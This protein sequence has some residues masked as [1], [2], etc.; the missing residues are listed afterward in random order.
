MPPVPLLTG[1]HASL[2]SEEWILTERQHLQALANDRLD[3]FYQ[4]YIDDVSWLNEYMVSLP[5][6]MPN[7]AYGP[8]VAR[9]FG[10]M[11]QGSRARFEDPESVPIGAQAEYLGRLEGHQGLTSFFTGFNSSPL[12]GYFWIRRARATHRIPRL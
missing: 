5:D 8:A 10:L 4:S 3:D 7:K 12:D 6:I 9:M 11:V 1:A 2:A